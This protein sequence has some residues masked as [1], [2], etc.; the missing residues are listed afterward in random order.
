MDGGVSVVKKKDG[1]TTWYIVRRNP[2]RDRITVRCTRV[3]AEYLAEHIVHE[4]GVVHELRRKYP[5]ALIRAI[6]PDDGLTVWE[7]MN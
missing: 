3:V 6:D 7:D 5:A 1:L 2:T 4:T